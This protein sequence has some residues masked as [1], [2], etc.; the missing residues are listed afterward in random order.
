MRQPR[1]RR[2]GQGVGVGRLRVEPDRGTLE[3][4]AVADGVA[5]ECGRPDAG[6]A[7]PRHVEREIDDRVVLRHGLGIGPVE[8]RVGECPGGAHDAA[9]GC[10]VGPAQRDARAPLER[11]RD[12]LSAR[13][14]LLGGNQAGQAR[15]QPE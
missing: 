12:R 3:R 8:D 4:K 10:R 11:R 15:D 5:L 7:Q 1:V 13:H 2:G 14:R 9:G 6:R